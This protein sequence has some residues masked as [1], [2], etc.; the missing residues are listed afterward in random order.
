VYSQF[1]L[2]EKLPITSTPTAI[3][4]V[5]AK[6]KAP[7][8]TNHSQTNQLDENLNQPDI[9]VVDSPVSVVI[10]RQQSPLPEPV[11]ESVASLVP[12]PLA[13]E[14]VPVDDDVPHP[15]SSARK[16]KGRQIVAQDDNASEVSV[17]V[18]ES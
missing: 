16:G 11:V 12:S 5:P 7:L 17:K 6:P 14:V 8:A 18:G 15:I 4:K 2:A 10:S 13:A 1:S 9:F 3:A